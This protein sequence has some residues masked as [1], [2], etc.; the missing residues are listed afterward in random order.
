MTTIILL[1]IGL[2]GTWLSGAA[3]WQAVKLHL[4][5]QRAM[6]VLLY[7]RHT[8]HLR[9]LGNGRILRL[10]RYYP[11]VRF[12]A[13][14]NAHHDV[15]S[16]LGYEEPDWP[17][18]RPFVVRYDPKNPKNATVDPLDPTWIFPAVFLMVGLIVLYAAVH[19]LLS[20]S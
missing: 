3:L 1:V 9:W 8:H 14:D 7:W 4:F 5:S 6:G 13:S 2:M 18:D 11:V 12:E 17:V 20:A 19:P 15:V 10:R 16:E